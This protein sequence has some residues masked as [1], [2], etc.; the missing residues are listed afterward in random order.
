V[1]DLHLVDYVINPKV[2]ASMKDKSY[3][4][5]FKVTRDRNILSAVCQCPHGNWICSH[6]AA[7]TIFANKTELDENVKLK[8]KMEK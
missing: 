2:K 5:L 3:A 6:M 8:T 7:A 4:I 1:L